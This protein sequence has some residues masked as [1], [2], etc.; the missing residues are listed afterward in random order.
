MDEKIYDDIYFTLV[1]NPTATPAD[2]AAEIITSLAAKYLLPVAEEHGV[3]FLG[4]DTE[5][6]KPTEAYVLAESPEDADAI[7]RTLNLTSAISTGTAGARPAVR[8]VGVWHPR[9]AGVV[10]NSA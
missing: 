4:M 8:C 3:H 9:A 1:A 7:A 5:T 6:G 2:L 10:A